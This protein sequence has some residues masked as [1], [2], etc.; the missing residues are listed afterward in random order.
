MHDALDHDL[1]ECVAVLTASD[2]YARATTGERRR[3]VDEVL[4]IQRRRDARRAAGQ[5]YGAIAA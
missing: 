5:G 4:V 3:L 1:A 2:R